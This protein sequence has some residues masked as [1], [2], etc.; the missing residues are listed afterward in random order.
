[1][2]RRQITGAEDCAIA[3]AHCLLQV[4][5]RS[6]WHDVDSLIAN[7]SRTGNKLIRALPHELVIGNIVRRVLG[8][9]RDEAAE[10]RTE[11]QSDALSEG[12]TTPSEGAGPEASPSQTGL[13]HYL[14]PAATSGSVSGIETLKPTK[15]PTRPSPVAAPSAV[16]IPRSLSHLLSASTSADS[17]GGASPFGTSGAST[18]LQKGGASSNQVHALKSEVI[19]GIEEIMDEISQVDDQIGTLA[20]VQIRP[21]DYVLVHQP[22]H[23]VERFIL[24]AAARRKFTVLIANRPT[25]RV[26]QSED[27]PH[28]SFRK[29]L[30]AQGVTVISVSCG[31]VMAY[32]SRVDKVIMGASAI[33]TGGGIV[34]DAGASAIARAAKEH[35]RAVIV[36]AGIYKLSPENPFREMTVIEWAN[37]GMYVSFADGPLVNGVTVKTALTEFVHGRLIDT[38]ITNL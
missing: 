6:K 31:G 28:T 32:M 36:L 16:T 20:E 34:S 2:K 22:S 1:M 37:P 5:A 24:R 17:D 33:V 8:L 12:Q 10:D 4:V 7:V 15:P 23:T 11:P 21:G 13:S 30:K 35:G 29:K 38:Y 9:I 27:D 19:D 3:T 14:P 18:P 25:P 26:Q